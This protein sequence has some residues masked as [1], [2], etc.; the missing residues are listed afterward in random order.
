MPQSIFTR[1]SNNPIL[2]PTSQYKWASL[3]VYNPAAI[4]D[5]GEYHIF[6]RAVGR[7]DDWHSV[8]G[9]AVSI[10]GEHFNCDSLPLLDR[11]DQSEMRGLEDPRIVRIDNTFYLTYTAYDGKLPRV[12]IA[13][14]K[15]LQR[16]ERHG[17]AFDHFPFFDLG[18]FRVKWIDNKPVKYFTPTGLYDRT[19][20]A[21]MFPNKINNKYWMLF[22]EYII[23]IAT[24]DDAIHWKYESKPFLSPRNGNYF[25]NTFVEMGP[26]PIKTQK[27]WLILYHGVD[28]TFTYSIGI[29]ILDIYNPSHI[30]YRSNTPIFWP[31]TDYEISGLV[32]KLSDREKHTSM[33]DAERQDYLKSVK[34]KE[35]MPKVTFCCGAMIENDILRIYYGAGDTY[36][37]TATVPLNKLLDQI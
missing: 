31:E 10:D 37:C 1:S 18:G 11:Q 2:K 36:V 28:K 16:W 32:D 19:K 23:W 27:G 8:I 24:S 12:R 15:D 35:I 30:L 14:S 33:N 21:A 4:Y 22:N 7:G 13:S 9:H 6:Y 26:P 25:D 5:K 17:Y 20:S 34:E 3:K 29:L